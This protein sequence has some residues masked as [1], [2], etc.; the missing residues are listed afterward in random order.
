MLESLRELL[1][2]MSECGKDLVKH[3]L[4]K[5]KVMLQILQFE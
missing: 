3:D 1:E 4:V 5:Y 2:E